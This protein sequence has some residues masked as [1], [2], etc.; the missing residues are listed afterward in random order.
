MRRSV[1][2]I[3]LTDRFNRPMRRLEVAKFKSAF[4]QS[5]SSVCAKAPMR[6]SRQIILEI[7]IGL[8][9]SLEN[10]WPDYCRKGELLRIYMAEPLCRLLVGDEALCIR[11]IC[12]CS[13]FN[14]TVIFLG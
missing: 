4:R 10:T 13:A 14:M 9:S 2:R 1:A 5:C 11:R 12:S 3:H 7:R 6:S 8:F